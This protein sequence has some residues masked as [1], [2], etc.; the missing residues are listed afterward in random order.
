MYVRWTRTSSVVGVW[1]TSCFCTDQDVVHE[2]RHGGAHDVGDI[3]TVVHN[4]DPSLQPRQETIRNLMT[5]GEDAVVPPWMH[6]LFLGYGDPAE[7][8]HKMLGGRRS[9]GEHVE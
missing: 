4:V 8:Q 2:G 3:D 5:K 9:L 7:T 1:I 6:K